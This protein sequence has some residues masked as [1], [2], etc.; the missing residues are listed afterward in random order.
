MIKLLKKLF[1]RDKILVY[2]C[3]YAI[4]RIDGKEYYVFIKSNRVTIYNESYIE[5]EG[6]EKVDI[7]V[8]ILKL[9]K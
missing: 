6:V 2:G 4:C 8:K 7:L 9:G 1:Q 5:L 3:D